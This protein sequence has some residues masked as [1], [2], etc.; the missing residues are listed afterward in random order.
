MAHKITKQFS[1]FDLLNLQVEFSIIL[2]F[3]KRFG[4]G[5]N[6]STFATFITNG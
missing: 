2:F 5:Q 1:L 4:Y 3:E 6:I